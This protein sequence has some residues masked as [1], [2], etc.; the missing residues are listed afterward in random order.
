MLDEI[1]LSTGD[2]R[3][4]HARSLRRRFPA[5]AAGLMVYADATR[6]ADADD[7]NDGRRDSAGVFAERSVRRGGVQDSEVESGGEGS[8]DVDERE[9]GIGGGGADVRVHPRCRELI[10]DFEQVTYKENSQVIDKDRDPRA[11]A[12]YRMRWDTW[13]GRNAAASAE[14]RGTRISRSAL[15]TGASEEDN[16]VFDIDREHPDYIA[17]KQ[18]WRRYRDL[19]LGGEQFRHAR[20]GLSGAP[21]AGAGRRLRGAVEPGVLRELYR[22]D[23]GL[24]RGDTV[25]HASRC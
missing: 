12:S 9:A 6:G 15:R 24:V 2:A 21:A 10:K 5:H 8:G 17:R 19:Y 22:V 16:D 18:M 4:T 13:C 7:G 23:C 25:P 1:V 14:E 11:D 20:A 3:T